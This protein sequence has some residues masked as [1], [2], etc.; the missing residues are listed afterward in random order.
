MG[1]R[2]YGVQAQRTVCTYVEQGRAQNVLRLFM[3]RELFPPLPILKMTQTPP[4]NAA[5]P[6]RQIG[7][8]GG[9]AGSR[10]RDEDK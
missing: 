1:R 2:A 9:V 8:F 3:L 4:A 10:R 7:R 5:C 6:G